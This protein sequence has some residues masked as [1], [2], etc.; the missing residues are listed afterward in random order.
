MRK[1]RGK[2]LAPQLRLLVGGLV[3]FFCFVLASRCLTVAYTRSGYANRVMIA[4]SSAKSGLNCSSENLEVMAK[5]A[6][7]VFA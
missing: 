6:V 2:E 5:R 1:M 4:S 3:L 7:P